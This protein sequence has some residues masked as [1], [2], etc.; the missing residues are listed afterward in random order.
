MIKVS[1]EARAHE[2]K[3]KKMLEIKNLHVKADGKEI[4][5]GIDLKVKA[6]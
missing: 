4:L 3:V 1:L 2:E 5:R 6:G